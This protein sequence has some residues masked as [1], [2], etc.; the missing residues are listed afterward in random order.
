MGFPRKPAI[1]CSHFAV[2]CPAASSPKPPRPDEQWAVSAVADRFD[3]KLPAA[4]PRVAVTQGRWRHRP[5]VPP[6]LTRSL[7]MTRMSRIAID[8]RSARQ[9]SG[10]SQVP[11]VPLLVLGPAGGVR[12]DV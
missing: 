8:D 3:L 11:A 5:A 10:M 7:D 6:P 9:R 1:N 2:A 12:A 4:P